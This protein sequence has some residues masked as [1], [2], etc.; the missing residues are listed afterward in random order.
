M[1]DKMLINPAFTGSS[2]YAV[3]TL[4]NREQFTGIKNHPSTN[5][6]NF[7]SALQKYHLGIGMKFIK[8]QIGPLSSLQSAFD[9]SY[10]LNLAGGKLSAGFEIGCIQKTTNYQDLILN[11]R[12]DQALPST[13][14]TSFRLDGS[15]GLYYQKKQFYIGYADYHILTM[16]SENNFESSTSPTHAYATLIMGNVFKLTKTLHFEPSVLIKQQ[17]AFKT[18]VDIN[19]LFMYNDHFGLGMQYRSN[20]AYVVCIKIGILEN[21]RIAYSY[22]MP[23]PSSTWASGP[24]HELLL[25]Y[26]IKLAPPPSKKEIHPRY[27][28]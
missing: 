21:L 25:S 15:F 28:Y 16:F 22:D 17:A 13:R 12:Q 14:T 6:F 7:H 1:F 20:S 26:G 4:K 2:N 18:Q 3:A 9:L 11:E 19:A 5:T 8:D 23:L 10:H 27:Y 24:S